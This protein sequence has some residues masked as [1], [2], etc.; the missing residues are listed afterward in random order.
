M[1]EWD[2]RS[3]GGAVVRLQVKIWFQN[4]RMKWRN[5]KERQLMS[6]GCRRDAAAAMTRHVTAS[7]DDPV[8]HR[9][10]CPSGVASRLPVTL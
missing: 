4:R 5:S 2:T 1:R 9:V 7:R 10:F 6:L 3:Q 8:M